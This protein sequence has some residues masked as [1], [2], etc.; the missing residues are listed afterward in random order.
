MRFDQG[1]EEMEIEIEICD[2]DSPEDDEVF[3]V[4]L[5][6]PRLVHSAV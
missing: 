3:Y 2:D 1:V 4:D 6:Q 5:S